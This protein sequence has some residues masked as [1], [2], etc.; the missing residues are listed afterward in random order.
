MEET[1]TL[2]PNS[3]E[4]WE[5]TTGAQVWVNVKDPRARDSWMQKSVGGK[6]SQR[7]TIT[8]GER[9]FNEEMVAYENLHL[10]PFRNGLLIRILPKGVERSRFELKDEELLLVLQGGE[11]EQFEEDIEKIT[12]EVI[13]RRLLFLA[14]RNATKWRFEALERVT[15]TKFPVGKSSQVYREMEAEEARYAGA[16]F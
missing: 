15:L 4:T 8:V 9:E 5:S 6:G 14:E 11:D 3:Q 12:S 10:C 7:I 16:S 2:D 1:E 13:L